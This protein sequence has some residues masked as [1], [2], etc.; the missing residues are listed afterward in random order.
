MRKY[1]ELNNYKNTTYQIVWTAP[2]AVFKVKFI[3]I[4]VYIRK[5]ARTDQ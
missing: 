1:I 5:K 3:A 4:N 2:T